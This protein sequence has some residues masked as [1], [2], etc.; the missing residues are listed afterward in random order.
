MTKSHSNLYNSKVTPL[1]FL[2]AR[3]VA[4]LKVNLLTTFVYFEILKVS[5]LPVEF[6]IIFLGTVVWYYFFNRS[7]V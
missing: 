7:T 3:K 2:P 1:K 6:T 5:G 4:G